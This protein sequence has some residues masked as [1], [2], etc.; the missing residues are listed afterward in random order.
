M[1]ILLLFP[2]LETI[3]ITLSFTGQVSALSYIRSVFRGAYTGCPQGRD[4]RKFRS[5]NRE[6]C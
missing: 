4:G 3:C 5:K 1:C 6:G 2:P